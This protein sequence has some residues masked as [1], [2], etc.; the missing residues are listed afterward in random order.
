MSAGAQAARGGRAAAAALVLA[1]L[2]CV[3][4]PDAV[5][6]A[7]TLAAAAGGETYYVGG[8]AV[9]LFLVI[10][11]VTLS[12]FV[13]FLVPGVLLA[14]S[15]GKATTVAESI[16]YGFVLSLLVVSVASAIVQAATGDTLR[17]RS[18]AGL[19]VGLSAGVALLLRWRR[20]AE[21]LANVPR[22]RTAV[23]EG[24]L[25]C[26]VPLALYYLLAPKL[27]WESF[28]GD[29]AH[30]FESSRLLLRQT[31][32]FW[33]PDAGPVAGFPGMTSMLFTFPNGW[34][35]RLFGET[36]YA[37]RVPFLLYLPVLAAGI[38]AVASSGKEQASARLPVVAGVLASLACYAVAMSFS[39]TYNPYSADI[40][41]PATQDTL[42]MIVYLVALRAAVRREYG[43][44]AAGIALTYVSL[45]SGLLL[46]G[47]WIAARLLAERPRQW[48]EVWIGAG[49]LAGTVLLLGMLPRVLV[50]LGSPPPGNEYGLTGI[51]RYFAFLQFTDLGRLVYLVLPAGIVPILALFAWRRQDW[52]SRALSLVTCAYFFFFVQAHVSLHHFVPAMI[53]PIVVAA[54][55][56]HERPRGRRMVPIWVGAA[57][58][59]FVLVFPPRLGVHDTGRR[60]GGTISERLGDYA[61]SDPAVLRGSSLL[62]HLFPF[63]WDP[64]VPGSSYGGSPLVW[65]RYA[66]HAGSPGPETN[67]LL[68]PSSERAPD[69]WRLVTDSAGAALYVRSDSL[70][71]RHRAVRPP[72]PAGSRW[73]T[74]P[75]SIL[76]RSVPHDGSPAIIDVA[77]TL[78][79][80]GV[81]VDPILARLGVRRDP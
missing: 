73:L 64:V 5:S 75:R 49:L 2:P 17:G 32:P 9:L 31:L 29:G 41:L 53:L 58:I 34:F 76:F 21:W 40:A 33:A 39:A 57:V 77:A 46:I 20:G 51:L 11:L 44:F 28:N 15:L 70:W 37:V 19:L 24:L 25:F 50:M 71:I 60:I 10:P 30:A 80:L 63:D 67:Y 55:M 14:S 74:V 65:N 35:L 1:L 78:E 38:V 23:H 59:A 43:W 27:L 8:H 61:S 13:L 47:F 12:A 68:T 69:G 4:A 6:R 3:L 18:Y 45:P 16:F 36:E 42:L 54:R 52:V 7:A 48:R 56:A 81:D 72:T 79:A 62:E 66:V 26:L 22:G